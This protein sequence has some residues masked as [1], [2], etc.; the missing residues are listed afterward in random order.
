MAETEGFK[1]PET[2]SAGSSSGDGVK[3]SLSYNA[4]EDLSGTSE[5]SEVKVDVIESKIKEILS[6]G[7]SRGAD[8]T[9]D[10]DPSNNPFKSPLGGI[11]L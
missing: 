5:K 10:N 1:N 9:G 11:K 8:Y 3:G 2:T 7:G 6:Q 4:Y